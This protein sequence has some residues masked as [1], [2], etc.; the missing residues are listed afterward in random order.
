[1]RKL[2]V[3]GF[4]T[5]LDGLIFSTR[6]GSKSGSF[7]VTIGDE[8]MDKLAEV[9]RLRNGDEP[10]SVPSAGGRTR[11]DSGG[12]AR[13]RPQ[14]ELTPREIQARLR[15]GRTIDEVAKEAKCPREWV[16]KFAP[17][18]VAE[19]AQ[20][21]ELARSLTYSKPGSVNLRSRWA[22]R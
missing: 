17:P 16:E 20:V 14:S 8:L 1:M 10:G 7:V 15:A 21:V 11:P 9:E 12:V 13:V 2:H 3:V 5:D 4:T 6:K 19:Q 18:I 22:T